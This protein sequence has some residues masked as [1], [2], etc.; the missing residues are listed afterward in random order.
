MEKFSLNN[1]IEKVLR[2]ESTAFLNPFDARYVVNSLKK[3]GFSYD[4]FYLFAESEK[5]IIYTNDL[6]ITLFEIKARQVLTHREILGALFSHNLSEEVFG[7]IIVDNCK[8]YIVVL[9]KIKKYLI[10]NFNKIGNKKI[11]LIERNLEIVSSF[12]PKFKE[13]KIQTTSLRLDAI[14]SKLIPTSRAISSE[15]ISNQKVLVNYQIMKNKNCVLKVDDIF[16]IRGVGKFKF[17]DISNTTKNG[18]YIL[19]IKKYL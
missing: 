3:M 2:G 11:E 14:I 1:Q 19:Y 17:S 8:C 13:I 15:I 16:S 7:D 9:D 4:V 12:S 10:T 18:K 6:A 5:L